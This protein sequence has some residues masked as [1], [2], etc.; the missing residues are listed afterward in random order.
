MAKKKKRRG[1]HQ[2]LLFITH[3]S[4]RDVSESMFD[5]KVERRLFSRCLPLLDEIET[6]VIP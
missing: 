3:S 5:G 6:A 2:F 1:V 4:V